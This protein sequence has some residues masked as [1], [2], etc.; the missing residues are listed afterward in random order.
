MSPRRAAVLLPVLVVAGLL[1]ACGDDEDDPGASP[2]PSTATSSAP[3]TSGSPSGTPGTEDDGRPDAPPFPAD[4]E[5]DTAQASADAAVTVTGIRTGRHDG[6]DRVVLDVA[7]TGTPGWDVRYVPEASSQ[8]SGAP[9]AVD[10]A[11]ILQVTLTGVGYPTE[12]GIEEYAGGTLPGAGTEVV[13][14]V[15]WDTTFEGTSVAFVGTTAQRPFRVYL[16]EDPTRVVL[17]VVHG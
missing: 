2:P 6:Y 16:V 5:P 7:G 8:G 11:A 10:G 9:I 17:D 13:T 1:S 14:E 15:V 3:A 12:T 4:V